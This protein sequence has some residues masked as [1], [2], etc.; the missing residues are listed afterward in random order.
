MRV[1][2]FRTKKLTHL[3]PKKSFALKVIHSPGKKSGR[4]FRL[5]A[6]GAPTT[7]PNNSNAQ[8]G[9]S[10]HSL[11]QQRVSGARHTM[12][13]EALNSSATYLHVLLKAPTTSP[14]KSQETQFS[15]KNSGRI[16][17]LSALGAP[18]TGPDNSNGQTGI[19]GHSNDMVRP[20]LTPS[21][22]SG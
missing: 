17:R 21:D 13:R 16:F 18:T 5:S 3:C 7:G 6:P 22:V 15:G 20:N 2:D 10:G 1:V 12:A 4:I 9:I 19:S 8:T 14:Q 11:S